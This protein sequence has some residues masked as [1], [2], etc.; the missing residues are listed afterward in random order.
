LVEQGDAFDEIEE[1]LA[2]LRSE[3]SY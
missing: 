1:A 3:T 2:D